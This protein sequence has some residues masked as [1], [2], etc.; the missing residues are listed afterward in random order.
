MVVTPPK[1]MRNWRMFRVEYGG[2]AEDCLVEGT[3]WLP[4]D[5]DAQE[6]ED[7]LNFHCNPLKP[8]Q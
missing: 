2:H 3:V 6:F 7:D 8:F 5:A 1:G 4:A